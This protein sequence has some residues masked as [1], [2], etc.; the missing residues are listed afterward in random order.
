MLI[1]DESLL[2]TFR[3]PGICEMCRKW[4]TYRSPHH[5]VCRGIGGGSRCDIRENLISLC[6]PFVGGEN[7]HDK[8]QRY[9]D[10]NR[11]CWPIIEKREKLNPGEAE[12]RVRAMLL[13]VAYCPEEADCDWNSF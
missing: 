7:C 9:A 4:V 1:K 5:V 3:G 6:G 11:K 2:D 10:I 8:A 13:G 12:G